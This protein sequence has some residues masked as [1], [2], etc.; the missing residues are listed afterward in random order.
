MKNQLSLRRFIFFLLSLVI[1]ASAFFLFSFAEDDEAEATPRT[2]YC[3]ECD[4]EARLF[5]LDDKTT[6]DSHIYSVKDFS[7]REQPLPCIITM[8]SGG[9]YFACSNPRCGAHWAEK[10][11]IKQVTHDSCS[12]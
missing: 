4:S 9:E 5:P 7:G 10:R 8:I 1:A 3:P 11:Y 6:V 12:Q 2:F